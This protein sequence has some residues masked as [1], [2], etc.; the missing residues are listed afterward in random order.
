[1]SSARSYAV[2]GGVAAGIS[3]MVGGLN[4]YYTKHSVSQ[5]NSELAALKVV[6]KE[7]NQLCV[8]LSTQMT[9]LKNIYE[10]SK[11][12]DQI[13]RHNAKISSLEDRIYELEKIVETLEDFIGSVIPRENLDKKSINI[14]KSRPHGGHSDEDDS[15]RRKDNRRG[16]DK[17]IT[18]RDNDDRHTY[19][20][21]GRD[22]D[23]DRH[24]YNDR[25]A[26]RERDYEDNRRGHRED[27]RRTVSVDR[28]TRNDDTA[29]IDISTVKL[30]AL[31]AKLGK[32]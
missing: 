26:Y 23:D 17:R 11:L 4:A 7:T 3:V 15:P 32:M 1:M 21:R 10:N 19:R 20:G 8:D 18:E 28:H 24:T 25:R 30:E 29:E 22:D 13:G 6:Q 31:K 2:A 16:S 12:H 14:L 27:D 5:T 9:L